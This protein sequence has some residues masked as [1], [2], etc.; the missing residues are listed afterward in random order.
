MLQQ[1]SL[2]LC[3]RKDLVGADTTLEC[4]ENSSLKIDSSLLEKTLDMAAVWCVDV[5]VCRNSF[6]GLT[7]RPCTLSTVVAV[8]LLSGASQ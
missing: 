7:V 2:V 4:L 3:R 5:P 8:T 6:C 1:L